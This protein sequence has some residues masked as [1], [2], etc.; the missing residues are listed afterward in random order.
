MNVSGHGQSCGFHDNTP[1]KRYLA[2]SHHTVW[3]K[4][5]YVEQSDKRNEKKENLTKS[6]LLCVMIMLSS[7]TKT[8][9]QGN[10][11]LVTEINCQ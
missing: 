9:D 7:E 10:R 11:E 8:Q 1:T 2:V 5:E 4:T 3:G 6:T